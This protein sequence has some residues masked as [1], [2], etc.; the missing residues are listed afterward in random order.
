MS[1]RTDERKRIEHELER[2]RVTL[3]SVRIAFEAGAVIGGDVTGALATNVTSLVAAIARHDA[4]VFAE[5][6]ATAERIVR[7]GK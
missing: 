1:R 2:A 5:E 3:D 4:Y 6:D 7:G